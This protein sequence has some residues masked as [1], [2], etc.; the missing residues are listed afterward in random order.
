MVQ[1]DLMPIYEIINAPRLAAVNTT[2]EDV[3]H[4]V[5]FYGVNFGLALEQLSDGQWCIRRQ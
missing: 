1:D 5:F 2:V 3:I 4:A